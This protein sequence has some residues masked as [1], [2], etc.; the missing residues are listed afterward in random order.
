LYGFV[1]NRYSGD[2]E[3]PELSVTPCPFL[4]YDEEKAFCRIYPVRPWVCK[5]YPGPG[6][7]CRGG[8]SRSSLP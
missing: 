3:H 5:G 8:Q 7:R 4:A 6:I 1:V 2:I